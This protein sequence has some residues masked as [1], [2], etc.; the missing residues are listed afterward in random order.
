MSNSKIE[1]NILYIVKFIRALSTLVDKIYLGFKGSLK[2]RFG[3]MQPID[4]QP[5]F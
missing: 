3:L 1:V 4:P 5:Y 2:L